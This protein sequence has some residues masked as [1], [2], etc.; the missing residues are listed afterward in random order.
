MKP[1]TRLVKGVLCAVVTLFVLLVSL[2]IFLK[3]FGTTTVVYNPNDSAGIRDIEAKLLPPRNT[4][5]V[6]V[7]QVY[8]KTVN[9]P[10]IRKSNP[11]KNDLWEYN[12][13]A[14]LHLTVCYELDRVTEALFEHRDSRYYN[15]EYP[16]MREWLNMDVK[17]KQRRLQ[18]FLDLHSPL[19]WKAEE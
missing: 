11:R 4:P 7:E 8:G 10:H 15:I 19:P 17:T 13:M 16:D 2:V 14:G 1:M 6:A 5:R 9:G 12:P 3:F 18:E